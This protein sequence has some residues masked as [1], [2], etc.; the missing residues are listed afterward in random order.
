MKI[1]II[2]ALFIAACFAAAD[3]VPPPDPSPVVCE[4]GVCFITNDTD[5]A[6]AVTV[7]TSVEIPQPSRALSGFAP[8]Q[9]F[10]QFLGPSTAHDKP[11]NFVERARLKGGA[12]LLVLAAILAGVSL[13]LTPC[14]LPLIPV[15]IAII[16]RGAKRGAAF[17]LGI[18]VVFG[19]L[20]LASALTGAAFG[21]LQ[22]S[23]LFNAAAAA[24]FCLLALAMLDVFTIDFS[25][26]KL[27]NFQ[28]SKFPNLPLAGAFAGGMFS[29][30]LSGAC[31]APVL[32][33]VLVLSAEMAGRGEFAGYIL[34]FALGLGMGLPWPFVGG[35]VMTL[36]RAGKWMVRVKQAF[37]L[38]FIVMAARSLL[39]SYQ[40]SNPGR[41]DDGRIAWVDEYEA[42]SSGKPVFVY[43]TADWCGACKKLSAT[44]LRDAAVLEALKEF[45]C[46][47]IDC[48]ILRDPYTEAWIGHTGARGLP[49][50]VIYK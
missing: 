43:L 4:D 25:R 50:I 13:N 15:N 28:I 40:I 20:G 39:I 49:H 35:G 45:A 12:L 8:P 44:T 10:L 17:G 30:L 7:E 33:S 26:F 18:A 3:T 21:S 27:P 9:K 29:A 42:F 37:A 2:S 38:L 41:I 47:K 46:V 48:T 6:A 31:V 16:G 14:V 22:S 1:S 5:D 36:P 11:G 19:A 24:V 32:I 34:P 23:V